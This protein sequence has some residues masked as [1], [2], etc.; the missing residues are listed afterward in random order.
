MYF[1]SEKKIHREWYKMEN[2]V[3]SLHT[4]HLIYNFLTSSFKRYRREWFWLK[5]PLSIM[6]EPEHK[7]VVQPRY[8]SYNIVML[9][10]AS[11]ANWS[12][13]WY[14]NTNY[15][16]AR[17]VN[18]RQIPPVWSLASR[19]CK[20]YVFEFASIHEYFNLLGQ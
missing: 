15:P 2:W 5:A 7:T 16:S 8:I 9:W 14:R 10:K 19:I 20:F 13:N 3:Q 4:F 11:E 18:D 12:V 17:N 6:M 1:I